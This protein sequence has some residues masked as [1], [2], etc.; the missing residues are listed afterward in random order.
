MKIYTRWT[1]RYQTEK[2][3]CS[4]TEDY[5]L[6]LWLRVECSLSEVHAEL[7]NIPKD[8]AKEIAAKANLGPC[9]T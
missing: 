3:A 2:I 7:G 4:F 1:V 5:K 8:S 9:K 6:S